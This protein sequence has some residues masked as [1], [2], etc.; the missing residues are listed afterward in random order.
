MARHDRSSRLKKS[1]GAVLALFIGLSYFSPAQEALRTLPQCLSLTVG[2][3]Q[4]L[5]L[6]PQLTLTPIDGQIAVAAS[7]D[8]T[9]RDKGA[10]ELTSEASGTSELMLSLLGVLPIRTVE[11][12]VGEEQTL[13]PGGSAL[14]IAMRTDGVLVVGTGEME[15]GTSPAKLCG[16]QPGDVIRRINGVAVQ[17]AEQLSGLVA[18]AGEKPLPVEFLR[19]STV[20]NTTLTPRID[21]ATGTARMGAWVR[22]STAGVG[23]LSYYDPETL[24]YGA[25]GHAITDGDTGQIMAVSYGE[26]L[27]ADIIA[28]QK[29]QAGKPGELKGS[30]MQNAAVLGDIT[31]NSALGVY[32]TLTEPL[33]NPLY[34]DG[35]PIGRSGTVQ[36]GPATI[37]STVDG[38]G[39]REYSI[40]IVKVNHQSSSAQKSM[41]IRVTDDTL[42]EKTGGIV[43]GMSGSPIIQNG[44]LVGAVT[45]VLVNDP[46]RGYGIFIENMLDAAS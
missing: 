30:F 10:V 24:A 17:S 40:E 46:T 9:L 21:P 2:D 4:T 13:I 25:L 31:L 3:L 28:V 19:G 36:P 22:D 32:G 41:L 35:L 7:D 15:D 20:I 38:Q 11:V 18:S 12:E 33:K 45:H 43:Q 23:T 8:E 16:I 26:V 34:P 1:V 37:L 42:L 14:G 44:R 6:G 29:G 39:M 27:R 5:T